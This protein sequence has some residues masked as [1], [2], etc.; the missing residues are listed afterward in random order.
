M[1]DTLEIINETRFLQ[2]ETVPKDTIVITKKIIYRSCD[3]FNEI[4]PD[5]RNLIYCKNGG[6][7]SKYCPKCMH[8]FSD[9]FDECVYCGSEL[10]DGTIE[11]EVE[12]IQIEKQIHEMTDTE[13]LEK[14]SDYKIRIEKQLGRNMTDAEFLNGIKEARRDSLNLKVE[15]YLAD[16][17]DDQNHIP[18]CPTCSSTDIKKISGLSKI[19]SVSMWGIFSQK[20]HKQWHCNNCDSEW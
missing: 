7:M 3:Y 6:F 19:V 10:Q 4:I 20:V 1:T 12:D 15:K 14:Y 17:Q 8:N 18:K 5:D 13:I 9:A 11:V 2:T 16:N